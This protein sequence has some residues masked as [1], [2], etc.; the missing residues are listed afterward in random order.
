MPAYA[1]AGKKLKLGLK[2]NPYGAAVK[3]NLSDLG[4]KLDP[5]DVAQVQT[6]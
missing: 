2:P 5:Y 4:V 3:L 1:S 6:E